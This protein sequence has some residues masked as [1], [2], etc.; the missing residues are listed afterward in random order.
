MV[1]EVVVAAAAVDF[2]L[3]DLSSGQSQKR[4]ATWPMLLL[5]WQFFFGNLSTYSCF[6]S[7][8]AEIR[9]LGGWPSFSCCLHPLFCT[10]RYYMSVRI[11][12]NT[13]SGVYFRC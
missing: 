3:V 13:R 6:A 4:M 10:R 5:L 9:V 2:D 12:R 7:L 11:R 8:G 1:E